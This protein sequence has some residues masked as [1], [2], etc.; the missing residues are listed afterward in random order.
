MNTSLTGKTLSYYWHHLR[1]FPKY[2]VPVAIILPINTLTNN[3]VPPLILAVILNRLSKHSFVPHHVW[4]SFGGDLILYFILALIGG[5][6]LWRIFDLFYWRLEG[7]MDRSIAREV[8][9][10]LL[11]QSAD[12]HANQFAGSLVSDTNKLVGSYVR[13]ADTILFQVAPLFFG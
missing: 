13:L 1:R 8:F 7:N 10:H 5:T 9:A 3:Y 4:S 6:V 11:S 12:F 2:L